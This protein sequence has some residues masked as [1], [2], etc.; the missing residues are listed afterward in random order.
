MRQACPTNGI[1][2]GMTFSPLPDAGKRITKVSEQYSG[3]ERASMRLKRVN[4]RTLGTI[5]LAMGT[6]FSAFAGDKSS[7]HKKDKG[8]ASTETT[9]SGGSSSAKAL[10]PS[11]VKMTSRQTTLS[12]SDKAQRLRRRTGSEISQ[13]TTSTESTKTG[14]PQ[15]RRRTDTEIS[16]DATISESNKGDVQR[17]RRRTGAEISDQATTTDS[18]RAVGARR[19]RTTG[20]EISDQ[21]TTT[22]SIKTAAQRRRRSGADGATVSEPEPPKQ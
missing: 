8:K 7:G 9:G 21:T 14:A 22:E 5:A 17:L 10:P 15:R 3:T 13:Q 16:Q 12:E 20:T 1:H 11:D 6:A 18:T 4:I 19:R 2:F